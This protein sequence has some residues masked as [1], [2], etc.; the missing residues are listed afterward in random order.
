M[1]VLTHT[2]ALIFLS[3]P[4][5]LH[6][7]KVSINSEKLSNHVYMITGQG[8]NI[9]LFEDTD[10]LL[11]IDSQFGKLTPQILAEIK[12]ISPKP[13]KTLLN[14]H[15]HGDHTGGN[16]NIV[17]KGASVFAHKNARVH[18]LKSIEDKTKSSKKALPILTFSTELNLYFDTTQVL[19]FHPETA[20]TDGDAIIY[21]V[22]ENVL[23][24]GDVFFNSRYPYIDLDSGGSV[25]GAKKAIEHMLML[26]NAETQIIPG[27]GKRA[28]KT[29]LEKTLVMYNTC[30]SRIENEINRGATQEDVSQNRALTEDLDGKFYTEGAF[31]SPEKWRRTI[32]LSLTSEKN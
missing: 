10:A 3:S 31:I 14:T 32:Y 11:M 12:T 5:F 7:Q 1:K 20:H 26:I 21:F 29:D 18:L 17:N 25:I 16:E 8:G 4:L 30:I 15:H 2:L 6:S 27:H 23:H 19:I 22:E 28:T 13:I 24:T 9:G